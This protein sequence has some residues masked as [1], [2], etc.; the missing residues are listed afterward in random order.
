MSDEDWDELLAYIC[1]RIL[2]VALAVIHSHEYFIEENSALAPVLPNNMHSDGLSRQDTLPADDPVWSYPRAT[3]P[4]LPA[5]I[6]LHKEPLPNVPSLSRQ[7]TLPAEDPVWS[8]P[9]VAPGLPAPIPPRNEPL[10]YI[11]KSTFDDSRVPALQVS[12]TIFWLIY[13]V[14]I[15]ACSSRRIHWRRSPLVV[16]VV[17]YCPSPCWKR[18]CMMIRR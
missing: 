15:L 16:W 13:R 12:P 8:Y 11:P 2:Y 18:P 1:T 5:T 14:L 10:L 7:D 6:P 4:A 3:D 17:I 9:Q